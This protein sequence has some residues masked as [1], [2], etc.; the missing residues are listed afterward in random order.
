MR[1][2]FGSPQVGEVAQRIREIC[3]VP[4]EDGIIFDPGA[5]RGEKIREDAEYEGVRVRV[6]A[7]LDGARVLLAD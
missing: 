6:P 5:I 7:S 1:R 3:A 4:A 2:R